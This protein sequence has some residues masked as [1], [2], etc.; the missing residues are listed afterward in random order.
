MPPPEE[1]TFAGSLRMF[2]IWGISVYVHWSWLLV[3]YFVLRYR[4]N[5]YDS[6][7][8]NVVEYLTLFAIVLLHEF[9]HVLACRQV[10]GLANE[11]VLWPL[12]RSRVCQ[13]AR[14]A[15]R[16]AVEHRRRAAGKRRP[17]A[18]HDRHLHLRGIAGLDGRPFR[19]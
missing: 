7:V 12:G 8:W 10:G 18:A 4:T 9:G 1:A 5:L 14:P 17:G 16:L 2:R 11:I 15:G 13:S 19:S 6:Q 3:A